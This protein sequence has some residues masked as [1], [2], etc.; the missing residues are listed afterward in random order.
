MNTRTSLVSLA[1]RCFY[2]CTH[3]AQFPKSLEIPRARFIRPKTRGG[4]H[5]FPRRHETMSLRRALSIAPRAASRVTASPSSLASGARQ[6]RNYAADPNA[7]PKVPYPWND[8]MNPS[9]W[10]EEHVRDRSRRSRRETRAK[11]R[12]DETRFARAIARERRTI[13]HPDPSMIRR[14]TSTR[15][16][17]ARLARAGRLHRSRRL[18]RGHLRREDGLLVIPRSV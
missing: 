2:K 11:T 1:S 9:N 18:G 15:T 10:K 3:H 16:L 14:L 5:K 8:P 4:P 6:T 12:R 7:P 13:P 17:D